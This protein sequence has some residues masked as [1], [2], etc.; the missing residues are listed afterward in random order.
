VKRYLFRSIM[1]LWL[2][3]PLIVHA[4]TATEVVKTEV[5]A[6]LEILRNPALKG[7][8]GIKVKRQKIE[9]TAGKLFDFTELSKRSLGLYWNR[10]TPE[11]RKEFEELYRRLLE[12]AYVDRIT[13]YTNEKIEFT[14]EVSLSENTV[15]VKS[16]VAA[17]SG[18]TPIYYMVMR[19]GDQWGVYD[20]VIEGVSLVENY[21][22]QFR[23]ILSS[24]STEELLDV[25]RRKVGGN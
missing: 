23:E 25:L 9:V 24:K 21:R 8:A 3:L 1:L 19:K 4:G 22:T 6:V 13:A 14:G 10:F 18:D 15:E 7:E 2:T 20:V 11:Q 16:M 5:D 12:D 17:K